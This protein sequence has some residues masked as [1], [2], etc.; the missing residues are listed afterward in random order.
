MLRPLLNY[1][2]GM[3]KTL[4]TIKSYLIVD[5]DSVFTGILSRA[6]KRHGIQSIIAHSQEEA[7]I[8]FN[9]A[10]PKPE[11]AVID[12]NLN[13]ESGLSLIPKLLNIDPKLKAIVMTGY[14]SIATTVEAMKLGAINY[15]CKPAD[16]NEIMRAFNDVSSHSISLNAVNLDVQRPSI[17]RIEWEYIQKALA[18]NDGNIS[19]TA[20]SLG[21]HRR[22]L[23][24]KLQKKPARS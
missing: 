19:A 18:D 17:D 22:T 20:R 7:I 23:Q 12:L 2:V 16:I 9:E 10:N 14:S 11:H 3:S 24:R 15:L 8:Q 13:G 6:L 5:D 21:M 1:H 4:S